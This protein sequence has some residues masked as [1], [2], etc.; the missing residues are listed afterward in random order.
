VAENCIALWDGVRM[1]ETHQ[2][3]GYDGKPFT[4]WSSGVKEP[5]T[6]T[7]F[8]VDQPYGCF[9][10]DRNPKI[11]PSQG[12]YLY[13]CLSYALKTHRVARITGL[14]F[15]SC[16]QE[17]GRIE[18]CAALVEDG[19]ADLRPF[20]L[21]NI[22]GSGLTAIGGEEPVFARAMTENTLCATGAEG[23]AAWAAM[24]RKE[25]PVKGAH[26]YYRYQDGKLTDQHLWPWP[27]NER[28]K[29]LNGVDLTA[30]VLGLGQP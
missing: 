29:A 18:N 21:A 24:F 9:S 3:M 28:I 20:Y 8:G 30:T 6:Y 23:R 25:P 2:A 14:F 26:L 10:M 11:G 17:D 16:K 7:N 27:M 4:N 5:H 1:K 19:V 22:R 15:L 13:G 12:P